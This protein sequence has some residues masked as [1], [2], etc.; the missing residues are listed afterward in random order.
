MRG[1][2]ALL[3][4]YLEPAVMFVCLCWL[5]L[6]GYISAISPVRAMNSYNTN[7]KA[8]SLAIK[9]IKK[10]IA[11]KA[12]LFIHLPVPNFSEFHPKW[13]TTVFKFIVKSC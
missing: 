2:Q 7:H 13:N 6:C 3:I 9:F 8:G 11:S 12:I 5:A 1:V 4:S 10:E